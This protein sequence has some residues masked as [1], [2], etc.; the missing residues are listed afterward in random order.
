LVANPVTE[1]GRIGRFGGLPDSDAWTGALRR[2]S[3]PNR[4]EAW[5]S[6]L[7][8]EVVSQIER[9]QAEELRRYGYL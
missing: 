2:L 5:R 1:L 4:N 6:K 8:P 9:I 7:D 3:F